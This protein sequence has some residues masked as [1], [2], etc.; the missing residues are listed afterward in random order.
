M[1]QLGSHW[2]DFREHL[3]C[4]LS[5]KCTEK[6]RVWLKLDENMEN[7]I[8]VNTHVVGFILTATFVAK[9]HRLEHVDF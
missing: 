3:F 5:R 6:I 4:G 2:M 1:E 7:F 8:Y 9:Q